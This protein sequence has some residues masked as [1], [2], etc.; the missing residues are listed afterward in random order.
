MKLLLVLP[1]VFSIVA[2]ILSLLSLLAG[3][4]PGFMEDYNLMTFNTSA[5]GQSVIQD[6]LN[7]G[8]IAGVTIPSG[9][10]GILGS[11]GSE[12]AD[13]LADQLGIGKW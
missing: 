7:G 6:L 3:Y 11:L 9:A 1:L 4:K 12:V 2:F 10:A 5:L 8:S 13:Q